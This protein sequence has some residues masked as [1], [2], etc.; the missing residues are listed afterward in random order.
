MYDQLQDLF[1]SESL[2]NER[3]EELKKLLDLKA[4]ALLGTNQLIESKEIYIFKEP[5]DS[6]KIKMGDQITVQKLNGSN[7]TISVKKLKYDSKMFSMTVEEFESLIDFG[8][9]P[10][11]SEGLGKKEIQETGDIIVDFL[12]DKESQKNLD[13][14]KIDYFDTTN[15]NDIFNNCKS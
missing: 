1:I 12:N 15:D 8:N 11:P 7:K 6:K 2:E 3:Y 13:E 14:S 4:N 10:V 9:T 5:F